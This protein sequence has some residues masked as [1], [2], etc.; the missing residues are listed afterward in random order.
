MARGRLKKYFIFTK[1]GIQTVI[2]YRGRVALWCLGAVINALLMGLLW[3]AIY[4]FSPESVIGGY[5][6]PQMLMY[7]I[8]S[9]I[10]FEVINSDSMGAIVD[11]VR[12]GLIGMRLMKPINYR[13]QLGFTSLG[14]FV[15]CMA[16][17]GI[18]MIIMGLI[19]ALCAFGLSG[20][21]WYNVLLF[22]PVTLL[23]ALVYDSIGFLFGQLAFR[24]QAMFG[25]SSMTNVLIGFLSG[26]MIPLAIYPSWAQSILFY[27][28]FP[29][30]VSLPVRLFLGQVPWSEL[31]ISVAVSIAWI[32]VL[33]VIAH[34]AYKGSVRHVVVFGG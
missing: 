25:V 24:T 28:P 9:A 17:V 19:V 22:L 30:M 1:S 34:F 33:N 20:I 5:T 32:I 16:I 6:F 23:S 2:A 27:T 31:G 29:T 8:L 11:D 7:V 18:P 12:Y 14:S 13:L 10:V 3:W 15:A 4:E 26:S 21:V